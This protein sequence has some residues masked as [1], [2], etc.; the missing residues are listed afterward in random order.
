[1]SK[2]ERTGIPTE[3]EANGSMTRF[4]DASCTNIQKRKES[5]GTWTVTAD[6]PDRE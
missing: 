2:E 1:M 5:D 3:E 4:R 6:C